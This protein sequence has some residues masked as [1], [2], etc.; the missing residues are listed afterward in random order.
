MCDRA[1]QLGL[2]R[3]GFAAGAAQQAALD[4]QAL[5]DAGRAYQ[6][7]MLQQLIGQLAE[8]LDGHEATRPIG[9]RPGPYTGDRRRRAAA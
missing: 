5:L 9:R 7:F 1:A 3:A 4:Q 6:A 2:W 8:L